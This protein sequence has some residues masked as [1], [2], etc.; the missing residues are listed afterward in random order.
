MESIRNGFNTV[1]EQIAVWGPRVLIGL[2]LLFVGWVIAKV[3]QRVVLSTC[4]RLGADKPFESSLK[5]I[6]GLVPETKRPSALAGLVTF[7]IL[8]L[9]VFIGFFSAM[10][11]QMVAEPLTNLLNKVGSGIPNLLGAIVLLSVGWVVATLLKGLVLKGLGRIEADN[12]LKDLGLLTPEM[13]EKKRFSQVVGLFIYGLVILLFAQSALE[14]IGLQLVAS[15]VQ[16]LVDSAASI[17]P[18]LLSASVILFAAFLIA[19]VVR[20]I[21][22]SGLES[23]NIDKYGSHVGFT[24]GE[25]ASE[26]GVPT[27]PKRTLSGVISHLCFWLIMLFA[28]PAVLDHLE[29]T[30]MVEPL[31]EVWSKVFAALPNIGAAFL[32]VLAT[33]FAVRIFA[34]ILR[35]LLEG[36]GVDNLL[37]KVGLV[38]M[39]ETVDSDRV[40]LSPSEIVTRTVI[41]VVALIVTQEVL[42][43]LQMVYLADMVQ[44]V[45]NYL[46]NVLVAVVVL[47]VAMRLGAIA[48][49]L[50]EN[51]A[52][53]LEDSVAKTL[54][55]VTRASVFVF[56]IT[57]ALT[58]LG[59]GGQVVEGSVLLIIGGVSLAFAISVGL[60]A[61]PVVEKML[62]RKL[63]PKSN[64]RAG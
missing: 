32:I 24:N 17:L 57:M 5:D 20:T 48:G 55:V 45:V 60:G 51:A 61:K 46:P 39:Q 56:G 6:S 49:E 21:V 7:W 2:V 25:P 53:G 11:L 37:G 64:E 63:A 15:T 28:F 38:K 1:L 29:L 58:Q 35:G 36:L 50:A 23:T 9:L 62:E 47:G 13:T 33:Y 16:G 14:L 8:M 27:P 40:R 31:R 34:P 26:E 12:R 54:G 18:N 10:N 4:R 52:S 43:T 59:V 3:S 19:S 22:K 44:N 30:P 41:V 42:H